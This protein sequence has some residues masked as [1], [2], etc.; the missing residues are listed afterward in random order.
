MSNF[1]YCDEL[2]LI[3]IRGILNTYFGY[4]HYQL[5]GGVRS[6]LEEGTKYGLYY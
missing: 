1:Y 2:N 4:Y 6:V 3:C 5:T